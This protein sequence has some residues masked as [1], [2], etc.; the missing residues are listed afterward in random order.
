MNDYPYADRFKV[1]R[2]LPEEGRDPQDIL[3]EIG[4]HGH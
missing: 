1:Y 3:A 2:T 4:D